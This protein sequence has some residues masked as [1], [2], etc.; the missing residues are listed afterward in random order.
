[1]KSKICLIRHGITEGNVRRLYYGQTDV[2]LAEKGIQELKRLSSEGIYPDS[3]A[4][5]FYT[6][7]LSRT[8]HTLELIYGNRPHEVI[9]DLQELNFGMFEMKPH[10]QLMQYGSYR[11]WTSSRDENRRPPGGES[12]R[13]FG[14][15][16]MRGFTTVRRRHSI[17]SLELRHRKEDAL[18]IVI[19]HGGPI[20]LILDRLW[21]ET[22]SDNMFA[23]IPDPGHG[24][25]L[26]LT[27]DAISG[28][29]R[30]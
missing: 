19:C 4:A 23:W 28:Y 3:P 18:S 27:D 12:I 2:A 29:E 30:F 24:Y 9:T 22:H 20:S 14:T 8:T 7:G 6:T 16:V 13:E 1:M 26:E 5:R 17:R 25:I 11:E 21:P 10:Q 15:R